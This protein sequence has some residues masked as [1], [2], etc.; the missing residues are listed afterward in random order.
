M[1]LIDREE[2]E[3]TGTTIGLMSVL[4]I[5][6]LF[7][8]HRITEGISEGKIKVTICKFLEVSKSGETQTH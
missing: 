5:C 4:S 2:V 7:L 6:G 8:V 1:I 3:M